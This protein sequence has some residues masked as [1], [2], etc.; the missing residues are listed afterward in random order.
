MDCQ[1]FGVLKIP[2]QN[3]GFQHVSYFHLRNMP[4]SCLVYTDYKIMII[5]YNGKKN[6]WKGLKEIT[7][8]EQ[9]VG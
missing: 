8:I 1:D 4:L 3:L 9:R 7:Y 6:V 5:K 2:I